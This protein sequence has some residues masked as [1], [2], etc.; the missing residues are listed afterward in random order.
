MFLLSR[1]TNSALQN[2]Y[3][4]TS[5][6]VLANVRRTRAIF[7]VAL[8][9]HKNIQERDIEVGRNLGNWILRWL[10][11]M[12][13]SAQI[14][15]E[16]LPPCSSGGGKTKT[17]STNSSNQRTTTGGSQ[18]LDRQLFISTR[19]TWRQSYPSISVMMTKPARND[20]Q[21]RHLFTGVAQARD[22]G[23][24]RFGSEPV[25]RNDIRQWLLQN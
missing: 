6:F 9:V 13:P 12:K 19:D 24:R 11:R 7:D 18:P 25:V 14:R 20:T 17:I 16:K 2:D 22:L 15:R 5:K 21:F 3:T 23:W 1:G 10:D 8:K 4:G